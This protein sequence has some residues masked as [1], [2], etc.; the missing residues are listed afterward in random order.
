VKAEVYC[1]VDGTMGGGGEVG[2]GVHKGLARGLGVGRGGVPFM[3]GGWL[4]C[5]KNACCF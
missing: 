4:S 5:K 1:C 3:V 2:D